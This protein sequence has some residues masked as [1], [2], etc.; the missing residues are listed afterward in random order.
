MPSRFAVWLHEGQYA[1]LSLAK[2][3]NP[4][5]F[6]SFHP[7]PALLAVTE[8]VYPIEDRSGDHAQP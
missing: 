6:A 5:H 1:P 7:L 3:L 4:T 2:V 8:V